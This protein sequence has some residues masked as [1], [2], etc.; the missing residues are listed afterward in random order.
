MVCYASVVL[1]A[2]ATFGRK[3][4]AAVVVVYRKALMED[5]SCQPRRYYRG[6]ERVLH[7]MAWKH[8][9]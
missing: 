2:A 7:N 1:V 8:Q 3:L 9:L 6:G 5:R 4:A